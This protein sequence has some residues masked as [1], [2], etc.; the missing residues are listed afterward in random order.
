MQAYQN[1]Y[2]SPLK[3]QSLFEKSVS[4]LVFTW[5]F[6]SF[7][8]NW[9]D[10]SQSRPE[11]DFARFE[12]S[13]SKAFLLI[14]LCALLRSEYSTE[15]NLMP[16]LGFVE[17]LKGLIF[18]KHSTLHGK[19][20]RFIWF[21]FLTYNHHYRKSTYIFITYASSYQWTTISTFTV[22]TTSTVYLHISFFVC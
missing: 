6:L 20:S 9:I 22:S 21:Y 8:Q 15:K 14:S 12:E 16:L 17:F 4:F 3:T 11:I 5:E 13:H 1:N 2:C 7:T 18:L 10:R 19:E